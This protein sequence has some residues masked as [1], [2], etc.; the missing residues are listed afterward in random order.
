MLGARTHGARNGA[1]R[2]GPKRPAV[3]HRAA[4]RRPVGIELQLRLGFRARRSVTRGALGGRSFEFWLEVLRVPDVALNGGP[5]W[6][7]SPSPA[8]LSA[9][10]P[11]P[12]HAPGSRES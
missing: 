8:L 9:S 10:D 1:G 2:A 6:C 11:H 5:L 12:P 3:A 4:G 7:A